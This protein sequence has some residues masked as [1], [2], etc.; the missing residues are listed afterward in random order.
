MKKTILFLLIFSLSIIFYSDN[1]EAETGGPD[2]FGYTFKDNNETD[3][4][5]YNWVE[6]QDGSVVHIHKTK[7]INWDRT[8]FRSMLVI[9][10]LKQKKGLDEGLHQKGFSR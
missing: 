4:P 2:N 5:E 10:P 3:G 1:I 7:T 8:F 9:L 6:I